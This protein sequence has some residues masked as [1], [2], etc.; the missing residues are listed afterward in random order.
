MRKQKFVF[1]SYRC[2]RVYNRPKH[3]KNLQVQ[4]RPQAVRCVRRFHNMHMCAE[5]NWFVFRALSVLNLRL[6]L[7]HEF[8]WISN[9]IT[10]KNYTSKHTV[11]LTI[12]TI[13]STM[14]SQ[15]KISAKRVKEN[16]M[17]KIMCEMCASNDLVKQDGY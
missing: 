10:K 15:R 12:R 2:D 13:C 16:N 1:I 7:N 3:Y 11:L 6:L 5:V 4:L 8:L 14:S 9:D 17:K